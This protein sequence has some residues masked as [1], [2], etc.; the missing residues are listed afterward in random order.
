MK[1]YF[2]N[3]LIIFSSVIFLFSVNLFKISDTGNPNELNSELFE[4]NIF[5]KISCIYSL[6][7]VNYKILQISVIIILGY[8]KKINKNNVF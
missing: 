8:M 6:N 4:R 7:S 1:K 3:L 2:N 5:S